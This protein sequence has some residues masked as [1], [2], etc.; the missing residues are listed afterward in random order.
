MDPHAA[1]RP[2]QALVA[3]SVRGDLLR[4]RRQGVQ[5]RCV[6]TELDSLA[7]A[8]HVMTDDL[9]KESPQ[10]GPWHP[11]HD[12]SSQTVNGKLR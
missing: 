10:S 12:E 8:L 11:A 4:S 9:L 7:T 3:D 5:R 1:C 2:G 6:K